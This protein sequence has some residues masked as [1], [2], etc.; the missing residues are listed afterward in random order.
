MTTPASGVLILTEE[1]EKRQK[2][3]QGHDP[4]LSLITIHA[5]LLWK[6]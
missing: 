5:Y 4:A 6:S 3:K 1:P 2:N